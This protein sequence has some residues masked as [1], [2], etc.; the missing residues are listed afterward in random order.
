MY[1]KYKYSKVANTGTSCLEAKKDT[2]TR[3][4]AFFLSLGYLILFEI[5][6]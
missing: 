3:K 1:K 4:E 6:W 2:F 5:L